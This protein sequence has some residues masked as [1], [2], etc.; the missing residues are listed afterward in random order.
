MTSETKGGEI[1]QTVLPPTHF[2]CVVCGWSGTFDGRFTAWCENCGHGADTTKPEPV[3]PRVARTRERHR[4]AAVAQQKALVGAAQLRPTSAAGVA[5]TLLATVVH[6][7]TALL[8]VGSI[9]LVGSDPGLFTVWIVGLIGVG[10]AVAVRPRFAYRRRKAVEDWPSRDKA[11]K[12]FALLD[13]CG[14]A[15]DAP[16]PVRVGFNGDFNAGTF[17]IGLLRPRTGLQI[18]VPLWSVLSGQERIALLGHELAHQING[19][20]VHG[21]WA[22]SA[23][24]SLREWVKLINPRFHRTRRQ[25]GFAA[26]AEFVVPY[27]M[28][29]LCIIPFLLVL[30]SLR[31]L[32]RLD[33]SCGQRSE[34]LADE[35]GRKLGSSAAMGSLL[36]KLALRPSVLHYL[37]VKA[38]QR[39]TEDPWPG[40]AAYTD[41]IPEH[42]KRRRVLVEVA[43]NTRIDSTHPANYLRRELTRERVQFPGALS[44]T[45]A[46]WAEIDAE[47]QPYTNVVA[48]RVLKLRGGQQ[49]SRPVVAARAVA[50]EPA[51]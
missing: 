15:L 23:Q 49:L 2:V 25:H 17:R 4:A 30:G 8:L 6:L 20:L 9:L 45:D 46:E 40:L 48:R 11:P 42:E 50:S 41:S 35:L 43:H 38:N 33:F 7:V 29:V 16:V 3:K 36:D 24:R 31:G 39:S 1:G 19:D 51:Q 32:R 47:L 18:G 26:L 10:T 12:L 21:Q 13:R 5:V 28:F 27:F 37:T 44:L 22:A 34:Y 14:T